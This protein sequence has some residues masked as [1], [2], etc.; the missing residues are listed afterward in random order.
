LVYALLGID[1]KLLYDWQIPGFS[2]MPGFLAGF[3]T[4][5]GGPIEYCARLLSQGYA[6][7]YLGA[8][9]ITAQCAGLAVLTHTY[10]R[11]LIGRGIWFIGYIPAML[12]LCLINMYDH[13]L[14]LVLSILV[15]L[16]LA[17]L[18]LL[19]VRRIRNG[20]LLLAV[21]VSML[22]IGYYL[23]DVAIVVFAPAA[24][25][26]QLWRRQPLVD[27]LGH[28]LPDSCGRAAVGQSAMAVPVVGVWL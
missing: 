2:T 25:I 28:Q 26:P 3:L 10:I 8:L 23:A 16:L 18:F 5:P 7:V 9:L 13:R 11:L 15:G 4:Y 20:W 19:A 14:S 27:H 22:L 21:F 24:A 1:S 12:A 6:N 17:C